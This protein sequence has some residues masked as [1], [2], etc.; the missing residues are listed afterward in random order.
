MVSERSE[1][2]ARRGNLRTL[3]SIPLIWLI[4]RDSLLLEEGFTR[5]SY[6]KPVSKRSGLR[7]EDKEYV[8]WVE[9][10][11]QWK[12]RSAHRRVTRYRALT[13]V[14]AVSA[15]A[16][17][18][19][20]ASPAPDW[21]AALLGFV[22]SSALVV[23]TVLQDQKFGLV[24]HVTAVKL[25]HAL[26]DFRFAFDE[27]HDTTERERFEAFRQEVEAI[28]ES[29]GAKAIELMRNEPSLPSAVSTTRR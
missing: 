17:G 18:L 6:F 12:S 8:E 10:F 14:A 3:L 15:L 26:R 27:S 11:V 22:S 5:P 4:V 25:Q 20:V 19:V 23:E 24:D 29:E 28:K 2:S 9:E 7:E 16:V 13:V 1:T 21:V